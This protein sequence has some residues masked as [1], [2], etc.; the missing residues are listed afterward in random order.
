LFEL[1]KKRL[2]L[3]EPASPVSSLLIYYLD[4][5]KPK[6]SLYEE[7]RRVTYNLAFENIWGL[8]QEQKQW[9]QPPALTKE[10]Q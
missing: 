2:N 1:E 6:D 8:W 3:K 7:S 4:A 10:N 9:P 5:K